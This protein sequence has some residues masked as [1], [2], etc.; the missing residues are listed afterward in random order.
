VRIALKFVLGLP[1]SQT[2]VFQR[3]NLEHED[4]EVVIKFRAQD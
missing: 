4:A 2:Y 1:G 3:H